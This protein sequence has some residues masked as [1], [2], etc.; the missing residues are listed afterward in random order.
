MGMKY[1]AVSTMTESGDSD[2]FCVDF[3]DADDVVESIKDMMDEDFAYV[4]E[5]KVH[6][7]WG[8]EIEDD[9]LVALKQARNDER[10]L[11]ENE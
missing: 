9:I 4:S 1:V 11:L 10:E 6:C 7:S 5:F 2:V 8:I 3:Y